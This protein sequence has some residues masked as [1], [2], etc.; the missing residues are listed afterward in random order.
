M[1][2]KVTSCQRCGSDHEDLEF[3]E[4]SNA[5]D[6]Y[7]FWTLCPN[8]GQPILMKVEGE[9]WVGNFES[10]NVNGFGYSK[11]KQELTVEFIGGARYVYRDVP[12][13]VFEGMKAAKSKGVFLAQRVKGYFPTQCINE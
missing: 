5:Q 11:D 2:V 4:L 1:L 6:S 13:E 10:S 8:L 9:E 7:R 12:P 3:K